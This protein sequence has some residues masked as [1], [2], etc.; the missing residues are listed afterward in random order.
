MLL[1]DEPATGLDPLARVELREQLKRLRDEGI[2]I[3]ISSH[4]LSDLE[5]IC[6]QI[7]LIQTGRNAT[8]A[9]GHSVIQLRAPQ[10]PV[11]IYEIEM[12]GDTA[13]AVAIVQAVAGTRVLE[14][15]V[16]RLVVEIAGADEQVAALL[17]ALVVGGVNVLRFDHRA[18]D[19]EERYRM[20]FREQRPSN[21]MI[22]KEMRQRMR[23]RRGWLLPSLYLVVL[24]A[25]VTFAYFVTTADRGRTGVQGS[26]VGV[27]LFLTL[28]YSQL[29]V[30][31]LL[32]PIFSAG[33]IT[34]EKEQRTLAG[35]LTSLLTTGQIWWGKFVASL[36]FVLLLLVTS[37]PVL[38]MAF[39]FGGVGPWEVFTATLTTVIILACVSAIGLYCSS[40]FQRSIHAT[41]VSY[42]TVIAISVVT[43]IA[44]FVRLTI[45]ESA[46]RAETASSWY[47]IPLNIRA[48]MYL[49]PFFF[50][51]ASFAPIKQLYPAW[52]T[53]AC[54]FLSLGGLAVMLTLRNLRRRGDV[55]E[56]ALWHHPCV[57]SKTS[58]CQAIWM[59]SSFPS[60]DFLGSSLN[61]ESSVT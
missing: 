5:D 15:S 50:L 36:L 42:A 52:I 35:L 57:R 55:I 16:G 17:R 58:S 53:C 23:E 45:Y 14:S 60:V 27:V 10:A 12:F 26:T 51:T 37:L 54:L 28:A 24:G 33:S 39:A 13:A 29:A 48:P 4:I 34:I 19:L 59:A 7:A 8:D 31:L 25:V 38:S 44:F 49:N 3:L 61:S 47:A 11:R 32:A 56:L 6:T 20:V 1:L 30:L 41:A 18:L 40:L 9:E 2:T 46:N 43:A 21:P 22:R